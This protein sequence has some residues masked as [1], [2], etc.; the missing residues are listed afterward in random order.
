M[1]AACISPD[2]WR[3]T[4]AEIIALPQPRHSTMTQSGAILLGSGQTADV[5]GLGEYA[6]KLFRHRNGASTLKSMMVEVETYKQL[7][8][9]KRSGILPRL[10]SYGFTDL[11][12]VALNPCGW[13]VYSRIPGVALSLNQI[14]LLASDQKSYWIHHLVAQTLRLE[15]ELSLCGP[16]PSW[17]RDY[18]STRLERMTYM[19]RKTGS[20]SA[21]DLSLASE[22][23]YFIVKHSKVRKFIHGDFNLPNIITDLSSHD[24]DHGRVRFVDP[25]V[26]YD[27]P[28]ANWRH[29]TQTPNLAELL[30]AEYGEQAGFALDYRLMYAIGAM[31]HLYIAILNT[32]DASSRRKAL[33]NCMRKAFT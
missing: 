2:L 12:S 26:D 8:F 5:W 18:A 29:F 27:A 1:S 13:A 16:L 28:E 24:P 9:T 25:H 22:L 14:N 3:I 23:H 4:L 6:I 19:A 7:G 32:E 15:R 20:I 31:S 10:F 30:A 33:D 17:R 11:P 21:M